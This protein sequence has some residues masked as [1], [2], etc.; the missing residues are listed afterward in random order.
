[1]SDYL[2]E[3][4]EVGKFSSPIS[5]LRVNWKELPMCRI[6]LPAVCEVDTVNSKFCECEK[7]GQNG[8]HIFLLQKCC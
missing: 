4:P 3:A 5:L 8:S 1:M 6:Q 2:N 7:M